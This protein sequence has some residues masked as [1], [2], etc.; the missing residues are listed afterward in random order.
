MN[1]T[2]I[3]AD[4]GG[5]NIRLAL[6][7]DI[8][9]MPQ[10]IQELSVGDYVG[11]IE[12]IERYL[13]LVPASNVT[14][15]SIAVATPVSGDKIMLTN[16]DWG[17]SISQV[18]DHFNLEQ[19]KVVNDFTGLALSLPLLS[20]EDLQQVGGTEPSANGAIALLGAGTGLGVSGL[21]QSAAGVYPLSGEG[22]HVTLGATN[23]RELAI[24][25]EFNKRYGHM[26]AERL[27]S[28]TG[29]G[30]AYEVICL[31]DGVEDLNLSPAEI[32]QHAIARTNAQCEELMALFCHWLGVVAGNLA[33]S[34]GSTGGVYIGGG[35]IPKLGD[36]FI[37][38][39]FR[40][41]FE[42]KGRF[43]NYLSEMPVYVIQAKQPALLGASNALDPRF[44]S[45]GI[46]HYRA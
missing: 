5:T 26:S 13:T 36:Y 14:K 38:S 37:Q 30:E 12:C 3:V 35:I 29:I 21:I 4:L 41:A 22:G 27:L 1:N 10:H 15:L 6:V 40:K 46:T 7:D 17:F 45:I 25:A 39:G 43:T 11:L 20:A 8:G 42:S 23:A 33:L 9:A 28:G 24:F 2:A 34:L 31:I 44:S 32:S 16:R 19:V 18:A